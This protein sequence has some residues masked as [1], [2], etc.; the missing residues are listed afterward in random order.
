[1]AVK[2]WVPVATATVRGS[3]IGVSAL[4]K[5]V[6]PPGD[7][8]ETDRVSIA[9]ATRKW[10]LQGYPGAVAVSHGGIT[11]VQLHARIYV[12]NNGTFSWDFSGNEAYVAPYVKVGGSTYYS[13]PDVVNYGYNIWCGHA[14]TNGWNFNIAGEPTSKHISWDITSKASWDN[15]ALSGCEFGLAMDEAQVGGSAFYLSGFMPMEGAGGATPRF[16]VSQLIL[17]VDAADPPP[18]FATSFM[19]VF[20]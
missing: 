5:Q 20:Q 7:I 9:E 1:V 12:S 4:N 2:F 8:D 15:D 6:A 14:F 3:G 17:E 18:S 16:N 11:K 19:A 13:L 10:R